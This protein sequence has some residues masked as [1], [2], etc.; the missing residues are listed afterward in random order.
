MY[1]AIRS[2]GVGE[3]RHL[4]GAFVYMYH[5]YAVLVPGMYGAEAC[6]SYCCNLKTTCDVL[7]QHKHRASCSNRIGR[8]YTK[9]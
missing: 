7:H 1:F 5:K 2:T 3:C 4:C 6:N 8:R 9:T